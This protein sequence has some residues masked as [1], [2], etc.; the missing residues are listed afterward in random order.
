MPQCTHAARDPTIWRLSFLDILSIS[1]FALWD[2]IALLLLTSF[3]LLK[4]QNSNILI[5][6][7]EKSLPVP[8][9]NRARRPAPF[10]RHCFDLASG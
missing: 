2:C 5:L 10:P 7:R 8:A 4:I 3:S 1:F 6:L 9:S